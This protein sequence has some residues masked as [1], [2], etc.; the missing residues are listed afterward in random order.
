MAISA[1]RKPHPAMTQL[2]KVDP[3]LISVLKIGDIAEGKLLYK[4]SKAAYFDLGKFGTGIVYGIE[5]TNAGEVLKG[6]NMGDTM[7]AKVVD[8]ENEE[9]LVELSLA[10][11]SKQK[12]WQEVKN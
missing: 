3:S 5:F 7:H 11:A 6:L 1:I 8:Q 4:K 10:Q 2:V 12:A 9:G